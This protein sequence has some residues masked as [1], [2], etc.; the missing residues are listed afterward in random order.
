M[1][2]LIS[3]LLA[4]A[5]VVVLFRSLLRVA[6]PARRLAGAVQRSRADLADRTG[7]LA[8]RVAAL[9]VVLDQRRR[10]RNAG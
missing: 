6:G 9:R 10:R 4:A 7:L 2:Y 5:G 3:A 1:P 8:T